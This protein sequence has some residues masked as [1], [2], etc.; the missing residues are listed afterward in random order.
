MAKMIVIAR[1]TTTPMTGLSYDSSGK[2]SDQERHI[3]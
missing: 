3:K 1:K 2:G